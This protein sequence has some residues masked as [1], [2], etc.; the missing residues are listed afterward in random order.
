M[1]R[2]IKMLKN[3][4]LERKID[5]IYLFNKYELKSISLL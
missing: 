2:R 4:N 1:C 5:K 3:V